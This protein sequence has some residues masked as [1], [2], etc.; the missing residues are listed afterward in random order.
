M[1]QIRTP[2]SVRADVFPATLVVAPASSPEPATVLRYPQP[3][4]PDGHRLLQ[5]VR[6]LVTDTHVYV[7]QDSAQGPRVVFAEPAAS[8]TPSTP[9]HQRRTRDASKPAEATVT[10]RTGKTLAF[11]RAGGCGC[12]SRLKTFDPF[13]VIV[14]Q[15]AENT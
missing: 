6:V 4:D 10:T 11:S 9:L 15:A 5:S 2:V 8:Y 3:D 12:G 14:A 7:F 13:A 1:T